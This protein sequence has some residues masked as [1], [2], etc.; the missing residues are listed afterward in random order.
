MLTGLRFQSTPEHQRKVHAALAA[1]VLPVHESLGQQF[2]AGDHPA[3]AALHRIARIEQ[4]RP[5]EQA[6]GGDERIVELV[7]ERAQRMVPEELVGN[8]C[9][10]RGCE[11]IGLHWRLSLR[12]GKFGKLSPQVNRCALR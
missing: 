1:E 3:G 2:V 6:A 4:R 7:V 8:V 5:V 11:C 12:D 10:L 9:G